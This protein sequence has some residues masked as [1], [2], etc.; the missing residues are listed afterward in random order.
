MGI[1]RKGRFIY[2]QAKEAAAVF[3]AFKTADPRWIKAKGFYRKIQD[4]GGLDRNLVV[5]Q[6][7]WSGL[8]SDLMT[9]AGNG[10]PSL[11]TRHTLR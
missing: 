8:H 5:F 2:F 1:K 11:I 6:P 3:Y 10:H 9:S 7:Y 4:L